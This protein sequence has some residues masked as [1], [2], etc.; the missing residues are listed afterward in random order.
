MQ[1]YTGHFQI[2]MWA[3]RYCQRYWTFLEIPISDSEEYPLFAQYLIHTL[4]TEYAG[5]L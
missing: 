4:F 1:Q 5:D 2:I 3:I